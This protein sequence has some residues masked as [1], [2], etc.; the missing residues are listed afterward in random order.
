MEKKLLI[1][2]FLL[3]VI[4]VYGCESIELSKLYDEDLE[5]ISEKAVICNEPY[6]RFGS[7]CCLDQDENNICDKDE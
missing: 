7:S 3:L 6:I 5:R 1:S 4:A 2:V